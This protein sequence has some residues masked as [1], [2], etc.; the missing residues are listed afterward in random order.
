MTEDEESK[1]KSVP[2]R[3]GRRLNQGDSL[4]SEGFYRALNEAFHIPDKRPD[5]YPSGRPYLPERAGTK[6]WTIDAFI[7]S[8]HSMSEAVPKIRKISLSRLTK[9]THAWMGSHSIR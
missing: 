4:S 5:S 3:H 6:I 8:T 2:S 9:L 1:C 7:H